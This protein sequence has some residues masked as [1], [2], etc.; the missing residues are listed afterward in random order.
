M[1]NGAILRDISLP[2]FCFFRSSETRGSPFSHLQVFRGD[3]Y[4][5]S[6]PP[7]GA[8]GKKKQHDHRSINTQESPGTYYKYIVD[9]QE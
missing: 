5:L 3:P 4:Q 9:I 2:A 6:Y 7:T 1:R 8:T